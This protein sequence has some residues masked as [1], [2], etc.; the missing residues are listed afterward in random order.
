[1]APITV[2]FWQVRR[3]LKAQPLSDTIFFYGKTCR[4][5]FRSADNGKKTFA[6]MSISQ[7]LNP[8]MSWELS[9]VALGVL[10]R[11]NATEHETEVSCSTLKFQMEW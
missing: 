5:T 8:E 3:R 9:F 7:S 10:L 1:M 6:I 4:V 2:L 11:W